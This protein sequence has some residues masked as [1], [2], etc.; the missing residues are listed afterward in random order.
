MALSLT[1]HLLAGIATGLLHVRTLW[2]NT[3]RFAQGGRAMA[4]AAL[5]VA[6]FVM[7]GSVLLLASLDGAL[8]LLAMAL[9]TFGSRM[10]EI[11]KFQMVVP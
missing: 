11:R 7:L 3:R 8:P 10:L 1:A 5:M 2:W 9:G 4:T 6:R